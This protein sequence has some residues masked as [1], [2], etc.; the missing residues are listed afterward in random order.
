MRSTVK[1]L[2]PSQ[3]QRPALVLRPPTADRPVTH[4]ATG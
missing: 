4:P 3:S 1:A 2:F